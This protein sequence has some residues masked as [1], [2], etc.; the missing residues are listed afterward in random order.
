MAAFL[1][2]W[3]RGGNRN[4]KNLTIGPEGR[5]WSNGLCSCFDTPGPFCLAFWCPCITY[6]RNRGRYKHLNTSGT[7][8]PDGGE[9]CGS[10]TLLYCLTGFAGVAC[11]LHMWNR[12]DIRTRYNVKGSGLGDFGIACCCTPCGLTQESREIGRASGRERVSR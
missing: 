3:P 4:A 5:E 2:R 12:G 6:G 10:D 7:A 1:L 8:H 11:L 9:T